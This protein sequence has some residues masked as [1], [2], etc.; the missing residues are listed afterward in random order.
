MLT[1][2]NQLSPYR[3]EEYRDRA[4]TL[5]RLGYVKDEDVESYARHMFHVEHEKD[6][7]PETSEFVKGML[8]T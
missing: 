7:V 4:T 2:W 6:N 5:I 3:Q 8:A 1:Q